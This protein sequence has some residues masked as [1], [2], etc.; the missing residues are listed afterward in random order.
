M[1]RRAVWLEVETA[2]AIVWLLLVALSAFAAGFP[3][4]R[5]NGAVDSSG[6]LPFLQFTNGG[7]RVNF[8]GY[9]AQAGLGGLLTGS[10]KD[11]GLH[12]SAGTPS[13]AHASAGLG[14]TIDGGPAGGL[15]ARAG[16]GNGGPEAE[17][18]L[19]GSV[20]GPRPQG[21]LYADS[22][23]GSFAVLDDTNKI[24]NLNTR[25]KNV[26][27][28]PRHK[29]AINQESSASTS[30]AVI[31]NPVIP[32]KDGGEEAERIKHPARWYF[33]KRLHERVGP[34]A[35]K[36]SY[37]AIASPPD[38]A[39]ATTR[40]SPLTQQPE[41]GPPDWQPQNHQGIFTR[42]TAG[43]SASGTGTF[44]KYKTS[45]LFDDIFNIPISAL[46]AVNQ[47]LKNHVG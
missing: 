43:T 22:S 40:S 35:S 38:H 31:T 3:A 33:R 30:S 34:A 11:G 24:E 46:N 23:R 13:G 47:L 16:L 8:G 7:I 21:I 1:S 41:R 15:H 42:A 5:E 14:G 45:T 12:A 32:T 44:P 29:K 18:G 27:I 39:E 10:S 36:T 9:H 2:N 20:A 6:A 37:N 19:A 4:A 26:Q 28:I 25:N 17:A